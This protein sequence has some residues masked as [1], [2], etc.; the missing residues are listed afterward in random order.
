[1]GVGAHDRAA[2]VQTL[3]GD[4]A[5]LVAVGHALVLTEQVADLAYA[6]ADV[7]GRDVDVLTD[8]A[9]QLGHER[10]AEPHDLAVG[11]A[12]GVEVA[13]AL[14]AAEGET[15]QRVLEDLL[16]SEELDRAEEHGRVEA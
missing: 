12:L 2:P 7:A 16:E 13:A 11:A 1:R 14:A 4:D 3:A 8:V 6:D 5:G 9:V 10:L 15:G